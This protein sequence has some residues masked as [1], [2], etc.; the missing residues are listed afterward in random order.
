MVIGKLMLCEYHACTFTYCFSTYVVCVFILDQMQIL[1]LTR[2]G[3]KVAYLEVRALIIG[4]NY[5]KLS[6]TP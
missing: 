4:I 6:G 1:S 2:S 3:S 5:S